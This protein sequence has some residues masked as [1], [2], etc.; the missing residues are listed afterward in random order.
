MITQSI[1]QAKKLQNHLLASTFPDEFYIDN[2]ILS[3][4]DVKQNVRI[5]STVDIQKSKYLEEK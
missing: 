4:H 3:V 2:L 1:E 5:N